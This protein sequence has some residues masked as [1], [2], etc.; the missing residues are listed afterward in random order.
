MACERASA[1][2]LAQ[3]LFRECVAVDLDNGRPNATRLLV[4]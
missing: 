3:H 2:E 1:R 4:R